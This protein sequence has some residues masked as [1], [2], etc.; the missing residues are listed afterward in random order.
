MPASVHEH[1]RDYVDVHELRPAFGFS[2]D[3]DVGVD[4]HVDV[5]GFFIWMPLGCFVLS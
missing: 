4:V 1:V 3:V 2:V 5:I